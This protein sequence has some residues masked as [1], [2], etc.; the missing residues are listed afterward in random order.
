MNIIQTVNQ[1]IEVIEGVSYVD[2]LNVG[3]VMAYLEIPKI[4][5]ELP[6]YHGTS[7]AVLQRG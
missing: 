3:E 4:D 6:I 2:L 1:E 5:V 7:D